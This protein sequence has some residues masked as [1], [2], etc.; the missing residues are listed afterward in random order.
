MHTSSLK[1]VI[2]LFAITGSLLSTQAQAGLSPLKSSWEVSG[3]FDSTCP[4]TG[5][6]VWSYFSKTIPVA[7]PLVPMTTPASVAP[8]NACQNGAS[9]FPFVSQNSKEMVYN[10]SHPAGAIHAARGVFLHPGAQCEQAIVRFTTPYSGTYAVYGQYYG[11][12]SNGTQ[13]RTKVSLVGI[14]AYATPVFTASVDIP[15]G[16]IRYAFARSFLIAANSTVDF[17]VGCQKGGNYNY[18]S[19]G[20][21]AVIEYWG[22]GRQPKPLDNP[23]SGA[24]VSTADMNNH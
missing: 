2:G 21:H 16:K 9:T 1:A 10:D 22:P 11:L 17:V 14:G 13:T 4:A 15:G 8:F 20:L 5:T 24:L 23:F 7:S 18:G 6:S 19:T 3:E 12:D